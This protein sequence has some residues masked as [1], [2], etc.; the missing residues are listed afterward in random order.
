MALGDRSDDPFYLR[1]ISFHPGYRQVAHSDS[2]L[3]RPLFD[4]ANDYGLELLFVDIPT[5]FLMHISFVS[6]EFPT[7][8]FFYGIGVYVGEVARALVT[9]RDVRVTV[10][11]AGDVSAV[12]RWNGVEVVS[13]AFSPTDSFD[14]YR[15][16]L[17]QAI[18]AVHNRDPITLFEFQGFRGESACLIGSALANIP[19]IVRVHG[20]TGA[21]DVH[22]YPLIGRL[23]N[24]GQLRAEQ[25][26]LETAC[27]LSCVSKTILQSV[28]SVLNNLRSTVLYNFI[29]SE[30]WQVTNAEVE[31]EGSIV[32]PGH[33]IGFA[34][35]VSRTKGALDVLKAVTDPAFISQH[36]IEVRFAGRVSREFKLC[37]ALYRMTGR[38]VD[39]IS[40]AGHLP[41]AS[42]AKFYRSADMLLIPSQYEPFSFVCLEAMASGAL[43]V[44]GKGTAHDELLAEGTGFLVQPGSPQSILQMVSSVLRLEPARRAEIR[45]AAQERVRNHFTSQVLLPRFVAE[46]RRAECRS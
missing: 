25:R 5:A 12:S 30:P 31:E 39:H 45:N 14:D 36:R 4:S 11:T 29:S 10:F 9:F 27:L 38:A 28:R 37:S 40:M 33:F 26:E 3:P 34:G 43:V 2:V 19:R 32:R 7:N 44:G 16:R 23:R 18:E 35:S 1:G 24:A 22:R 41:R 17:R 42:L 21:V 20:P 13:I 46:Y 15:S 6:F 8:R